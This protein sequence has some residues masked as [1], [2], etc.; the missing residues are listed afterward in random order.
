MK[1]QVV[2]EYKPSKR[3]PF[4]VD[5][6]PQP[7]NP[8][9]TD[10]PFLQTP[11]ISQPQILQAI[12]EASLL[13][14][15]NML[16]LSKN[17]FMNRSPDITSPWPH[18][19][20]YA[21]DQVPEPS[22]IRTCFNDFHA[23]TVSVTKRL[24]QTAIIQATSRLRSQRRRSIKGVMPLIKTRDVLSA[25]D[26]LGMKRDGRSRWTGVA[27]RC[28]VRVFDEQRTTR[29]KIK[30]REI[31]WSQAEQILGLYDAVTTQSAGE[32]DPLT[33]S[34]DD[35]AF[36][37]RAARHGTPL[38]MEHLSL[39]N[40][41]SKSESDASDDDADDLPS[42][43]TDDELDGTD[44]EPDD[45]AGEDA[46]GESGHVTKQTVEQFDQEARRQDEEVLSKRLGFTITVKSKSPDDD[47]TEDDADDDDAIVGS[48]KDDDWRKWTDYHAAWEEFQTPVPHA[49]FIANQK[50]SVQSSTLQPTVDSDASSTTSRNPQQGRK[51][52]GAIELR[53]QNPQHYAAMLNDAY[54]EYDENLKSDSSGPA[55]DVEADVPA[56]SIEDAGTVYST[57]IY[58]AMDWEA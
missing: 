4:S 2:C 26:V 28:N 35:G 56:Q 40:S 43:G 39:S 54:G 12:P 6:T 19:S 37:R 21:S 24:M 9:Q 57:G 30:Q 25:I 31:S 18:W 45:S 50:P 32:V 34:E 3:T 52:G 13:H 47:N 7:P 11:V 14:P 49:K 1:K 22:I 29:F 48:S 51:H 5:P 44:E 23:L 53:P 15:Q 8:E 36:K 55:S 10:E 16:Q 42:D 58:N 38:P 41:E 17:L 46:T 27:R 20:A 33:E